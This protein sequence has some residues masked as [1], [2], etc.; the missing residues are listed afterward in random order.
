MRL[1]HKLASFLWDYINIPDFGKEIILGWTMTRGRK[2]LMNE[3]MNEWIFEKTC[4]TET[5]APSLMPPKMQKVQ[6]SQVEFITV[7]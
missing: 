2:N 5:I 6:Y 1:S 4:I 3:W 7:C